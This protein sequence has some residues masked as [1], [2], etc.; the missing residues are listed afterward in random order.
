VITRTQLLAI[1][2]AFSVAALA[3]YI[4]LRQSSTEQAL[5]CERTCA[6]QGKHFVAAPTG[7]VGRS[8]EGS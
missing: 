6:Q 7:T 3:Q 2:A 4:L 5:A 8:V 1:V